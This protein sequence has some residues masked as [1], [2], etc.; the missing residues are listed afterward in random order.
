MRSQA[1]GLLR[2]RNSCQIAFQFGERRDSFGRVRVE[3]AGECRLVESLA[4]SP[5]HSVAQPS[6][7]VSQGLRSLA[8]AEIRR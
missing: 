8:G 3:D 2:R 5:W 1:F 7:G 6:L 4:V